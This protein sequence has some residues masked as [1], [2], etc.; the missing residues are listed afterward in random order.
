MKIL[1]AE[2]RCLVEADGS[3]PNKLVVF[4]ILNEI[5]TETLSQRYSLESYLCTT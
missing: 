2:L 4:Q 3:K 1:L 5:V